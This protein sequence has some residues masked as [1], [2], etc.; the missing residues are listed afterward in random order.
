VKGRVALLWQSR[1]LSECIAQKGRS[2]LRNKE[3]RVRFF[4]TIGLAL[5]TVTLGCTPRGARPADD[6]PGPEN[7]DGGTDGAVAVQRVEPPSDRCVPD[8]LDHVVLRL[9]HPRQ[10]LFDCL[11]YEG[12][13]IVLRG[14][15]GPRGTYEDD[16]ATVAARWRE[17][18]SGIKGVFVLR[19]AL[20]SQQDHPLGQ[21]PLAIAMPPSWVTAAVAEVL[22]GRSVE[23]LRAPPAEDDEAWGS[24][25][26]P[27][28]LFGSFPPSQR[29]FEAATKSLRGQAGELAA[30]TRNARATLRMLAADTASL[31]AASSEG[32]EATARMGAERIA[33]S[34]RRYFTPRARRERII[35]ITVENP[36]RHEVVDEG[37]GFVP[38]GGAVAERAIS[39]ARNAVLRR[40]LADGDLA[41]ERYDLRQ[42]AERVRAIGLLEALIPRI[43]S[44]ST[45]ATSLVWLWV[46]GTLD[47]T[48]V[49]G[50]DATAHIAGFRRE[51]AEADIDVSRLRFLSKPDVELPRPVRLE[52]LRHEAARFESLGLPLSLHL[53]SRAFRRALD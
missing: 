38:T 50:E 36:N 18:A 28:A 10:E 29:L 22:A 15:R 51:V 17:S 1:P 34:D 39:L 26:T 45:E 27:R 6:A 25:S 40:R 4:L 2:R 49:R 48:G 11:L 3:S 46:N 43:S 14:V 13:N 5:L 19:D 52:A 23:A 8:E 37:K 47:A 41:L 20:F 35:V 31:F 33:A 21:S 9:G 24:L 12:N 32:A 44:R 42:R 53:R 16:G 30:E 7:P